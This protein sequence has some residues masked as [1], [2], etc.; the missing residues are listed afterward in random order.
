MLGYPD[1]LNRKVQLEGKLVIIQR[2]T[3]HQVV[4]SVIRCLEPR[5]MPRHFKVCAFMFEISR[6]LVI[7]RSVLFGNIC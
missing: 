3:P 4:E 6:R 1:M 7:L 2:I 5:S